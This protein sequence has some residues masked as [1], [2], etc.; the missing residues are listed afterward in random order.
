MYVRLLY[1]VNIAFPSYCSFGHVLYEMATG[2]HANSAVVDVIPQ[3][4]PEDVG[5]LRIKFQ[6]VCNH[7]Q[8]TYFHRCSYP[9]AAVNLVDQ[10]VPAGLPHV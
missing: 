1:L 6:S 5:E 10:I 2:R 3:D 9:L 7:I 8:A 4:V